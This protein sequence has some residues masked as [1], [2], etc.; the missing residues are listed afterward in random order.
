MLGLRPDCLKLEYL[1]DLCSNFSNV[2]DDCFPRW[3][4]EDQR[5]FKKL[6]H[7]LNDVRFRTSRRSLVDV[8]ILY[9]RSENF[10]KEMEAIAEKRIEELKAEL[11]SENHENGENN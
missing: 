5:L 6:I 2:P 11:K 9:S 4:P 1:F 7:S 10:L 8:D 3:S